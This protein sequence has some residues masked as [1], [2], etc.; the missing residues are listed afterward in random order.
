[1]HSIGELINDLRPNV[2]LKRPELAFHVGKKPSE[3]LLEGTGKIENSKSLANTDGKTAFLSH[4]KVVN[5]GWR[6]RYIGY[7]EC[8]MGAGDLIHF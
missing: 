7:Y 8:K 5:T 6:S 1:M 4:C 2:R 3:L